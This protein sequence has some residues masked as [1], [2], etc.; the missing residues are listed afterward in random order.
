MVNENESTIADETGLTGTKGPV[1]SPVEVPVLS[2]GPCSVY[3]MEAGEHTK[4]GVATDP[5]KRLK[6]LQSMCPLEIHLLGHLQFA[7][8]PT[9]RA[10]EAD[11]HNLFGEFRG[12]GEWFHMSPDWALSALALRTED[13]AVSWKVASAQLSEKAFC[14]HP[15]WKR[16]Q[17]ELGATVDPN[18]DAVLW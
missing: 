1:E 12:H 9:A 6:T 8:F 3:V 10:V 7:D 14:P 16:P 18:E 17:D 13:S 11:L 4:I 2:A 15:E 5:L